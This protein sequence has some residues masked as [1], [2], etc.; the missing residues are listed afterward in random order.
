MGFP[1]S[2]FFAPEIC[3][4]LKTLIESHSYKTWPRHVNLRVHMECWRSAAFP[5][6]QRIWSANLSDPSHYRMYMKQFNDP[7]DFGCTCSCVSHTD[8]STFLLKI[9]I[10]VLVFSPC[11]YIRE[12]VGF[13]LWACSSELPSTALHQCFLKYLS[14]N[15]SPTCL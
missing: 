6:N 9:Y 5:L 4:A 12:R 15:D 14:Q 13:I 7:S 11:S 1:F 3:K 2:V 8:I 10:T